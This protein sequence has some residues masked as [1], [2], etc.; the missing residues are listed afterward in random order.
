MN[1]INRREFI[2]ST[3]LLLAGSQLPLAGSPLLLA[4]S[5]LPLAAASADPVWE[6]IRG[7]RILIA[8]AYNPPFYPSLDYEPEKAVRIAKELNADSL[9]YP[10][11]SYYAYFPTKSGYPVHPELKADIMRQTVDLCR[12]AGLK[13][14]AYVPLNH[15]FMN[16]ASNDPRFAGWS[17]KFADGRPMITGHYGFAEYYEGCLNS[18]VRDVIK[19]LVREVLVEYP[20]D[21]MYFDGPY[22]GMQNGKSYCHCV[23]CEAAYRK[24]F[25]K[26]VPDQ[27]EKVSREDEIQY[28]HWMANDVAIAFLREIREMIRQTRDVPVM[29]ND[30]SLLSRREWRSRAVPVADGFMFEAAE[31][32][33]NKLFNMQLGQSTGKVIWTY[34]G[35]HTQ[36]NREHLKDDHVRGWFSYPVESQELLLDGATAVAA[37][38]GLVYWGLPRFF[39]QPDGPLAYESG[40]YVKEVFDFQQKHDALLRSVRSRPQAGILVGDQT[41]DWYAGKHFVARGYENSAHGAYQAL[42]ANGFESEPFL[43]WQMSPE[44]LSRYQMIYAPNAVCLS[45]AQCAMLADYVRNGGKLLATHLTSVAN[46]YG[47]VRKNFGLADLFG[48]ELDDPEPVEIP[49]LYLKLPGGE[50]IPQDPQVVRFRVNGAEEVLA[51]T[52]DRGH[53][54]NLGPAI[55]RHAVGKG[56]VIYIGSSLEAVYEET[57]MKRLRAFLGSLVSPWLAPGRSYEIE[58]QSGVTPH[59]MASRDVLLLHLLADTGNK[60]KHLRAREEFLPVADVKVRI[61]VPQGR[62]VRSASLLRSGESLPSASR[63]G[64][65]DVTVPSVFVHEAVKVELA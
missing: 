32:P 9:R 19:A 24:K 49:D 3:G 21:V 34:V 14:V 43:D 41:I 1:Q 38:V 10:A 64:W 15:P 42:K 39:Y 13:N 50:E 22:Q 16:T 27:D 25:G 36:Y 47:R 35:T 31:T 63:D 28:T 8:E 29:F 51:E 40:R 44:L 54:A 48:A 45:D 23:Y 58:Y 5:P 6:W 60:N 65:L 59:F 33:E 46:E 18:P 20:F 26:P 55:V 56:S 62:S 17:K 37:G 52:I 2:Q 12:Q 57:L 11:A 4:G 61:R 30:A 53:R 7:T